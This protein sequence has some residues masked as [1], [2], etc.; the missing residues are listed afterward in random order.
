M[1][2]L[3]A[4]SLLVLTAGASGVDWIDDYG[5]ALEAARAADRPLLV[6]LEHSDAAVKAAET[7]EADLLQNYVVCRVDV[8]TTYGKRV[9]TAFKASLFPH[10]AV[11]DK[12]GKR[13]L[14][15]KSGDF[16]QDDWKQ[17][18]TTFKDGESSSVRVVNYRTSTTSSSNNLMRTYSGQ[19]SFSISNPKQ[20]YT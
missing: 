14:Y 10:T 11:I 5:T 6:L 18:L 8:S 4:T 12:K 15:R 7:S 16:T 20:C 13:I 3:V 1:N 9:A 2:G 19:S 17:M